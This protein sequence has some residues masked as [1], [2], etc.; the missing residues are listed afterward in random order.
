MRTLFSLSLF[1]F[2]SAIFVSG[3]KKE[4]DNTNLNVKACFNYSV[5]DTSTR[6][7][8]FINCSE[9]ANSF[10]WNFGDGKTSIEKEPKHVFAGHFPFYVT[11]IAINGSKKDSIIRQV[12]DQ[13]L[14]YKPNIYIYPLNQI[15]LSV[16][17][18]F[19]L[20]GNIIQ[21]IPA[22]KNGWTIS[23]EPNGLI[24]N[25]Y[26]YLFYE[27]EQPNIF[28]YNNG[29]CVAQTELKS[30][31]QKNMNSYNFSDSEIND[32]TEYWIP[33]LLGSK[34][35]L[36]YPQTNEIINN[37]I[38]L[39]LSIQP[40][41]VNRLYY[42]IIGVDEGVKIEEPSTIR[43]NRDGFVIMEWGVFLK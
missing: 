16:N 3:C 12:T 21:S 18:L 29:W 38:Q 25:K 24:N 34:Y 27:S 20:G 5:T 35:Y 11:L 17:I 7:V 1:V 41:N 42:G 23:V 10:L 8:Q 15:M 19:P 14:L 43:F 39:K 32:F 31:F 22:Y 40:N 37:I 6:E 4:V 13:I 28:Q 9:N 30:F 33:K 2:V 26:N 36:I